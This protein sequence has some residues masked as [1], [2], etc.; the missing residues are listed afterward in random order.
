[1]NKIPEA[2]G[3]KCELCEYLYHICVGDGSSHLVSFNSGLFLVFFLS[4]P[5]RTQKSHDHLRT[6]CEV[7]VSACVSVLGGTGL[8]SGMSHAGVMFPACFLSEDV[9]D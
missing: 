1:M 3:L 6:A 5:M 8:C 4:C 7:R 9:K 2:F